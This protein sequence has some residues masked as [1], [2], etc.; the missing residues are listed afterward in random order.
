MPALFYILRL[1][2]GTPKREK[3]FVLRRDLTSGDAITAGDAHV[4][5]VESHKQGIRISGTEGITTTG[6]EIISGD[7]YKRYYPARPEDISDFI[8]GYHQERLKAVGEVRAL[9]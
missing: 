3:G 2:I 1:S 7:N 6:A 9:K 5:G 4:L 8:S